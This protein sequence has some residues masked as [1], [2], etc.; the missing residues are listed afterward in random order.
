M[1]LIRSPNFSVNC[2]PLISSPRGQIAFQVLEHNETRLSSSL[3]RWNM[4]LA[5]IN[6]FHVCHSFP[7][8]RCL[9]IRLALLRVCTGL[10]AR[11]LPLENRPDSGV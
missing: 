2:S 7:D 4:P 11:S 1:G 8:C 3:L 10:T 6:L 9:G 5:I